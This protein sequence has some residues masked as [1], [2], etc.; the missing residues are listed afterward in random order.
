MKRNASIFLWLGLLLGIPAAGSAQTKA[1][2]KS[3]NHTETATL[4]GGCFW[5]TEAIFQML[6]GV[7]SVTSGYAGGTTEN[8]TY[9]QVCS[10]NTG[11]AEVIQIEYDP[12][13]VSYEKLLE[14]FWDAHDP[15]TLN[16]QG[17]DTGTQYRS[18]ILYA[19]EAQRLAAAKSKAEAQKRFEKPIVTEIA[20]L[21]H[22]YKAEGY[23]QDFFRSNTGH[24][25][26]QAVIRPK[27]E[28]M[29]HK[30]KE[31]QH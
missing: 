11:H 4:G 23:H 2:D 24:P 5:C 21:K 27:V 9:K 13:V 17:G 19:N 12:S 1:M 16:R 6:P 22:F 18:I 28:K 14:T 30:L 10:G 15:T 7:K 8:P 25:Y 20:P 31:A 3:T 29:E 26:C